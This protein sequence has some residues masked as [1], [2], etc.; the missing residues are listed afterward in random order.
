MLELVL[1]GF[2]LA[3]ACT[4][5]AV[6]LYERELRRMA[7]FLDGRDP[8]SNERVGV[9]FATSGTRALAR[10]VNATLDAHGEANAVAFEL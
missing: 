8:A 5:G 10:G 3:V 1:A 7:R 4:A 9:E 2:V 6:A